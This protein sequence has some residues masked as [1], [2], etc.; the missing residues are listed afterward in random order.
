MDSHANTLPPLFLP[1][2]PPPLGLVLLC[3]GTLASSPHSCSKRMGLETA[4]PSRVA[5]PATRC[6]H[7]NPI[8][9][10]DSL[11]Q[12]CMASLQSERA[13]EGWDWAM[14]DSASSRVG[15]RLVV[16]EREKGEERRDEQE[17]DL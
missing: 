8:S 7:A 5:L 16:L 12:F 13:C 9:P 4:T 1:P 15:L 2:P 10:S 14:R 11:D 3:E 6:S 17:R